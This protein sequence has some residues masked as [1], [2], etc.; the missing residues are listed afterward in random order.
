MREIEKMHAGQWYDAN[1]DKELLELRDRAEQ[2]CYD[3]AHTR[4]G[5]PEQK[6]A[7]EDLLT[8]PLEQGVTVLPPVYIDYGPYTTIGA[9]TFINHGC[10]LMDGGGITIGKNVFI[11]PYCGFYTAN[12]PMD[13]KR[14]NAG[15]E[16]ALP[17]V[18]G[19]NCWFGAGCSVMPGVTIGSGCVIAAGSVVTKD[20]PDNSFAAG[21]PA[22]VKRII[23]QE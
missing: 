17:I 4:P 15:L 1:F 16:V 23:D 10:Y 5:S 12:H 2:L 6:K 9:G 3:F 20:L 8:R 11:G 22:V 19:D 21:V 18:V 13:Y 14:R 7:L